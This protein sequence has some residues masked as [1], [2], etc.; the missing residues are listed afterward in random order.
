LDLH[1]D[2][3]CGAFLNLH[4]TD[5]NLNAPPAFVQPPQGHEIKLAR[6]ALG[7]TQH[8]AATLIHSTRRTW[9]DWEAGV[10]RMHCG[11]W[12]LFKIKTKISVDGLN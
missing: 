1:R 5:M 7:L 10:A 3:S 6:D 12:E 8:E 4:G 11:L 9:Q 2:L